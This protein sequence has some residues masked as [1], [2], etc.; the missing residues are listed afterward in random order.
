LAV[1][2]AAVV[3]FAE[4]GVHGCNDG[5]AIA[6]C[7]DRMERDFSLY[8]IGLASLLCGVVLAV[9]AGVKARQNRGT[10]P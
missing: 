1:G 3:W 5:G 4:W 2:A 10:P 7:A 6:S 9:A 8:L